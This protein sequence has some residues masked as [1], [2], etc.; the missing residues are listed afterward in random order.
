M[1]RTLNQVRP[2]PVTAFGVL[3]IALGCLGLLSGLSRP[4][5]YALAGG[6]GA[7]GSPS[8]ASLQEHAAYRAWSAALGPLRIAGPAALMVSGAGLLLMRNWARI[9]AVAYGVYAIVMA[10]VGTAMAFLFIV[11]ALEQA[12]AGAPTEAARFVVPLVQ[13]L[14]IG[15]AVV[16]F[17]YP[18]LMIFFLTR[19]AVVQAFQTAGREGT[20]NAVD[21]GEGGP[22]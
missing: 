3:N 12:V 8:L 20:H 11:P 14:I 22:I 7:H 13:A 9:L 4:L 21:G 2:A 17:A 19:G 6:A 10:G 16:G 18:S 15:A 5:L 1:A